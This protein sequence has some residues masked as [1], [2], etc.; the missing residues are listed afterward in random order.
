MAGKRRMGPRDSA[1]PKALLDAVERVLR[2]EGYA[3]AT[4]R[5]VAEEA[6]VKQQLV[7]YYFKSMEDLHLAAFKR[8]TKLGLERLKRYLA[9]K[10]PL[11]ALWEERIRAAD[12]KVIFEYLALANR[13]AGIRKEIK[14]F[15]DT[16]R[17]MEAAVL[18]T[19]YRDNKIAAAPVS[20]AALAF[21][22]SCSA[23]LLRREA[24]NGI[25]LAHDD[26]ERLV[27]WVLNRFE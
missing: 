14:H 18:S 4:S 25:T 1:V 23:I 24:A 2:R 5:R 6:G 21:L 26:F 9:S 19:L 16:S 11:H 22:I 3:A 27:Q 15:V 7:Y 20:P 17:Q 8:T 10:K 12:S 13:H